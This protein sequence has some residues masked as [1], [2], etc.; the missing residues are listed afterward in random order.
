[1]VS[2]TSHREPALPSIRWYTSGVRG[3]EICGEHGRWRLVHEGTGAPVWP[4]RGH[5]CFPTLHAAREAARRLAGILPWADSY[6]TFVLATRDQGGLARR[7]REAATGVTDEQREQVREQARREASGEVDVD[8]AHTRAT[9][10]GHDLYWWEYGQRSHRGTCRRCGCEVRVSYQS[11]G[12]RY[13]VS[14]IT[15]CR[16]DST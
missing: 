15:E 9:E 10:L 4:M 7:I 14:L 11:M 2:D 5:P 1:M 6:L 16:A 3:L 12:K 13:E 8:S